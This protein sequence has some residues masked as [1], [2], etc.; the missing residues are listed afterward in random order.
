VT[1]PDLVRLTGAPT[2]GEAQMIA[3]LLADN[4]IRVAIRDV[5]GYGVINALTP[6][7]KE[8]LVFRDQ[9]EEARQ[10]VESYFGLERPFG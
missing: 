2:D 9:L 5:P 6:G 8:L 1:E 10:L 7:P 3:S 4:G